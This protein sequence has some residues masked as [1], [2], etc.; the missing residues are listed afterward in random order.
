MKNNTLII[1]SV[2]ILMGMA[3]SLFTNA[4]QPTEEPEPFFGP[5]GGPL[6]FEPE[7]LP[8]AQVGV[9]YETEIRITQNNTPV[10][11]FDIPSG[12]LPVGLELVQVDGED[13]A[14]ISGIPE[15]AGTFSFV[16]EV[17]CFGTQVS[18]QEGSKEYT[19]VVAE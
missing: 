11:S 5:T 19:I 14:V 3:C 8:D 17:W 1:L 13:I 2:F 6:K 7:S 15:E 16:V 9:M 10:G 4:V 18:G 12:S